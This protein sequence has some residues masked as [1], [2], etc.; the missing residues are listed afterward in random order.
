MAI[1]S[2]VPQNSFIISQV[3]TYLAV[4]NQLNTHTGKPTPVLHTDMN[5]ST[6]HL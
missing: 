2:I 4:I 1:E 5:L 3:Q 6:K